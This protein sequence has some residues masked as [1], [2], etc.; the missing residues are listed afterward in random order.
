MKCKMFY[1][2]S[3]DEVEKLINI[4]LEDNKNIKIKHI[5]QSESQSLSDSIFLSRGVSNTT[6]TIFYE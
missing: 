6:I 2:G 4:F 5:L 1:A 3:S